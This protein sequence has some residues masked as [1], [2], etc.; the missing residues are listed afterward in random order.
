VW[1]LGLHEALAGGFVADLPPVALP[2][3]IQR[4]ENAAIA[5]YRG[6]A[7]RIRPL[8]GRAVFALIGSLL[9]A[10]AGYYWNSRQLPLPL[11]GGR[12]STHRRGVLSRIAT[13]LLVRR[14]VTQAGFF[15][16]LHS[17]FRSAPHRVVIAACSAVSLAISILLVASVSRALARNPSA[18]P[19]WAFSTQTIALLVMLAG[20]R[21]AARVPADISG[22]KLFRLSWV[23]NGNAFLAGVRRAAL[24][25]IVLPVVLVLFPANLYLL[26]QERALM[27]LISGVLLGGVVLSVLTARA[28]NL[29]FVASYGPTP[30]LNTV[31]PAVLVGGMFAISV[32]SRIEYY[33]LKD[34]SS[35]YVFWGVLLA[36]AIVPH[37]RTDRNLSLDLPTAFDVP[38]GTT[39]LD[40]G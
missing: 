8:A 16:T 19:A 13:L 24:V 6:N 36:G 7:A 38:A 26:G 20:F 3:R 30:D 37:I 22:N 5:R 35:A 9:L 29:P 34:L 11:V 33:A 2:P 40:L 4:E 28:T 1:F 27:H 15:L 21:H 25:G 31:G 12:A 14:P 18:P 10:I 32:Y 17:L 39:R 23:G